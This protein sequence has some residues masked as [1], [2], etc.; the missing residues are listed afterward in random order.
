MLFKD[1]ARVVPYGTVIIVNISQIQSTQLV[2][3][4]MQLRDVLGGKTVM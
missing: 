3:N 2:H 4:Y 1:K